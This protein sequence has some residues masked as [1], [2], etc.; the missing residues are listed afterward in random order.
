MTWYRTPGRSFTRPPADHDDGVLL[1]VVAFPWNVARHFKAIGE[2]YPRHLAERRIRLLRGRGVDPSADSPTLRARLESRHLSLLVGGLSP[3]ADQLTDRRH[4]RLNSKLRG[5]P[6]ENG[7]FG[8]TLLACH[9]GPPNVSFDVIAGQRP[10]A[11]CGP[12]SGP[13]PRMSALSRQGFFAGCRRPR[14]CLVARSPRPESWSPELASDR[15][16]LRNGD[17]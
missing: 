17:T 16:H 2:P 15:K 12:R 10:R 8:V 6:S 11:A 4:A 1:E 14:E 5:S 3:L 9:R 7:P 13:Q